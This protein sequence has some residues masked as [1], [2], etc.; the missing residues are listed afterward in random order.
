MP[1]MDN[2]RQE[3]LD[4]ANEVSK[5]TGL[6]ISTLGFRAVNDGN[7]FKRIGSGAGC[8]IDTYQSAKK[9]LQ[10]QLTEGEASK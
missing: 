7:F 3:L 2:F 8:G 1:V 10:S 6:A 9:W 5:K 4:L